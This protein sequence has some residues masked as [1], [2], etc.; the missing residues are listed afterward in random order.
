MSI[1]IGYI[2]IARELIGLQQSLQAD[3]PY[4]INLVDAIGADENANSR[5]IASILSQHDGNGDYQILKAFARYFFNNSILAD[6]IDSPTIIT[7]QQVRND[8]RIDI[9]I[10]EP[11]KYAIILENKVMDAP[12][13]PHQLANYI[14]GLNDFG[15]ANE[16]IYIAYLPSTND[17]EPSSNSWTNRLGHNYSKEF[18]DRFQN[19]S[20]RDN[21]LPWLR[22]IIFPADETGM[23]QKSVAIY[24]DYLE[25]LFGF[26]PNEH[27]IDMKT[28]EYIATT[29]NFTDDSEDNLQIAMNAVSEIDKLKKEIIVRKREIAK[30]ILA[31]WL[32][33]AKEEL[34]NQ[35]WEDR[36]NDTQFPSI[37]F[38]ISYGSHQRAF[39]V[40][41]QIDHNNN[42][43][44]YGVYLGLGCTMPVKE[45][46]ELLKPVMDEVTKFTYN[47]GIK[48]FTAH[49]TAKEGY[50]RFVTLAQTIV[51]HF[52]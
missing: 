48:M 23:L 40:F 39:K 6:L 24:I 22:Q 44:Y 14:E 33:K 31:D 41:I 26:R 2:E 45:A 28:D 5:I 49:T 13:Q 10:S 25:G 18:R 4:H 3:L 11:G 46:R 21:I 29:L 34:P 35:E 38:P 20:F 12:E 9:Y 17:T 51:K 15:F 8:K 50:D 42:Y 1:S 27:Y 19:V 37:G 30:S 52:G 36:S 16:Q 7:E 47:V 32:T 43:I